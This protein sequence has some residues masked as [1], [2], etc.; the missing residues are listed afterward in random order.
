MGKRGKNDHS[1]NTDHK[2]ARLSCGDRKGDGEG[3]WGQG[4]GG[5]EVTGFYCLCKQHRVT[6]RRKGGRE[7][8]LRT[9]LH[10]DSDLR[11]KESTQNSVTQGFRF[12][13]EG[14]QNLRTQNFVTEGFRFERERERE[15]ELRTLLYKD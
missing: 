3:K 14:T 9:L 4:G 1:H 13:R 15:R 5:G 7:R 12:E 10:K 11:E 6:S 8:E 2:T